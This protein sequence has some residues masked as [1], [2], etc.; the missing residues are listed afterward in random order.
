MPRRDNDGMKGDLEVQGMDVGTE[1]NFWR[2]C[3]QQHVKVQ[4]TTNSALA[5]KSHVC[6]F[7]SRALLARCSVTFI[8]GL[9]VLDQEFPVVGLLTFASSVSVT[10]TIFT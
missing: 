3:I 6:E 2:F 4:R 1:V 7:T 8:T 9:N 10:V 5:Y